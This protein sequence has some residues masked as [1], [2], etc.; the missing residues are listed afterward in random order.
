MPSDLQNWYNCQLT[1]W[2]NNL[3]GGRAQIPDHCH[4][5]LEQFQRDRKVVDPKQWRSQRILNAGMNSYFLEYVKWS[6]H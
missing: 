2:H 1:W 6:S 3:Q 5:R 4:D